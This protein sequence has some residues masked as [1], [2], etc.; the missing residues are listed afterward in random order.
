MGPSIANA[1]E[2]YRLYINVNANFILVSALDPHKEKKN[3]LLS[4]VFVKLSLITKDDLLL[5]RQ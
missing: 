4:G 5:T 2:V 3:D 1:L